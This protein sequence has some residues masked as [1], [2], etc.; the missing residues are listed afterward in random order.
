MVRYFDPGQNGY[1]EEQEVVGKATI[2]RK[3]IFLLGIPLVAV[4]KK[5]EIR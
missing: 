1:V 2:R 5:E 4:E 3:S